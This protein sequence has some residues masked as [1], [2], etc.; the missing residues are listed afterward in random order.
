MRIDQH[1][2]PF[3]VDVN[4]NPD[5]CYDGGFAGACNAAG[6]PYPE[7]ISNIISMA[8][9]RRNRRNALL[10]TLRKLQLKDAPQPVRTTARRRVAVPVAA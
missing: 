1:D 7:A 5:I 8:V 3:V 10:N 6:Y 4:P 9:A 2:Q